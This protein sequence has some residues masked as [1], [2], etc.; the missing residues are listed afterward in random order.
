MT[1]DTLNTKRPNLS[2]S[3]SELAMPSMDGCDLNNPK[4][5]MELFGEYRCLLAP[6]LERSNNDEEAARIM[7][8]EIGLE[9]QMTIKEVNGFREKLQFVSAINSR[10]H[11]KDSNHI[12]DGFRHAM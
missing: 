5:I 7:R 3:F 11:D 12:V 8:D 10:A 2:P 1:S 4:T 6:I 9:K